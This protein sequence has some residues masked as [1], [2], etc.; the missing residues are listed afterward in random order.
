MRHV[1]PDAD[2]GLMRGHTIQSR[3]RA[4]YSTPTLASTPELVG[5]IRRWPRARKA[6]DRALKGQF[7]A[8]RRGPQVGHGWRCSPGS[9]KEEANAIIDRAAEDVCRQRQGHSG[10]LRLG[11]SVAKLVGGPSQHSTH[12][13]GKEAESR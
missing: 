4:T 10:A 11:C 6:Y 1:E 8:V 5:A 2:D 9:I 7:T 3:I 12:S 13:I